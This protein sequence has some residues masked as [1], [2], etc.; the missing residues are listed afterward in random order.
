MTV[1]KKETQAER[2]AAALLEIKPNVTKLDKDFAVKKLESTEA[3]ISRYLNG[4]GVD[5]DFAASL[6]LIFRGRISEREK[7]IE[8]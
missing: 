4:T 5:A 3:T 1:V 6:L 7:V 2:I 8:S